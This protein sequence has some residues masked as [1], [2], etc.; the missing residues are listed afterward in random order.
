MDGSAVLA[1]SGQLLGDG[2]QILPVEIGG[3]PSE[4]ATTSSASCNTTSCSFS[5]SFMAYPFEGRFGGSA[6]LDGSQLTLE[7]EAGVDH[8]AAYTDTW[9]ITG[10]ITATASKIDGT[11]HV[12]GDDML[13]VDGSA[14]ISVDY[15]GV[16]LD[17]NGCPV[18]GRLHA[19]GT[20]TNTDTPQTEDVAGTI[21]FGPA[22]GDVH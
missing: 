1:S 22:C 11:L 14:A 19:A 16:A 5:S 20:S 9:T 6:F 21:T 10:T 3:G 15:E 18:G 4:A 8:G 7:L 17:T 2:E 12:S 13:D